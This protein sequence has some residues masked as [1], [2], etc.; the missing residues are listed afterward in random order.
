[1]KVRQHAF[2]LPIHCRQENW[3]SLFRRPLLAE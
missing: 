2:S 1:M 3:S